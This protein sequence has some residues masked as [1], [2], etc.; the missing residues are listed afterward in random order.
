[1]KIYLV[2]QESNVD[3]EILINVTPCST[4]D[5][6]R[7]EMKKEI[8]TLIT[9]SKPYKGINLEEIALAQDNDNNDC[10]FTFEQTNDSFYLSC[11][12][13]DYYEHLT[14]TEKEIV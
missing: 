1:M 8:D 14:I 2:M 6:A 12:Y 5:K 13:D 7:E 3:G 9:E 4:I 10:G 11:D